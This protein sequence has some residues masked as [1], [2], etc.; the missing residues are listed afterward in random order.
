M[1]YLRLFIIGLLLSCLRVNQ[2]KEPDM[3]IGVKLY[4]STGFIH[5]QQETI[6]QL[7]ELGFNAV[8]SPAYNGQEAFY[9]SQILPQADTTLGLTEFRRALQESHIGFA[10]I[11][12]VFYDPH[13]IRERP[14]L[15]PVD[16]FANN[17]YDNWQ[18]MVCPSDQKYRSERLALIR[19]VLERLEPDIISLDFIRY[20][21]TWEIIP[22]STPADSIRQFCFCDRCLQQ[23]FSIHALRPPAELND[24]DEV[25]PWILREHAPIWNQW[26]IGLINSFIQSC[27]DLIDATHP[28]TRLAVHVVPWSASDFNGRAA[29][30]S[31][32]D[33]R[34]MTK[35]ADILTPMIYHKR[36]SRPVTFIHDL[37]TEMHIP[38]AQAV[39]PS[40]Q[41]D[42]I[43]DE[44]P[45]KKD[46]WEQTLLNALQEPSRGVIIFHWGTISTTPVNETDDYSKKIEF[47][48]S[49]TRQ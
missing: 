4:P 9:P 39:L 16:Q 3:L 43:L 35:I 31:G 33:V 26:R 11:C 44:E 5:Q 14:D 48:K 34:D 37:T 40:I 28:Q 19:E 45:I 17:H 20:P 23:F 21:V 15:I 42:R 12:P 1:H 47:L 6:L 46:E 2:E 8:F 29:S 49:K 32:Q 38:G 41:F 22:F 24:P 30:I 36:I 27:R 25:A 18:T 10:A 13:I 7:N